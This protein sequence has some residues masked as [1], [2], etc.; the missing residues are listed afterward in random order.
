MTDKKILVGEQ[1]IRNAIPRYDGTPVSQVI[2]RKFIDLGMPAVLIDRTW[3]AH[4]DNIESFFQRLTN[5]SMKG[6]IPDET[7]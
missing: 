4:Q 3:Y 1:A 5:A 6:N 7:E 2:F